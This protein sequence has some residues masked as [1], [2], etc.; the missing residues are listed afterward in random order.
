MEY[1]LFELKRFV[2]IT[3]K[4]E[5]EPFSI[6]SYH[7]GLKLEE[8]LSKLPHAP[9]LFLAQIETRP[10]VCSRLGIFNVPMV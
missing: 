7:V 4:D 9:F 8:S 1:R 5:N 10:L 3:S 2:K 6:C